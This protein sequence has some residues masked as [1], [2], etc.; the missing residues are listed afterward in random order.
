MLKPMKAPSQSVNLAIL[1]YPLLASYKLDGVRGLLVDAQVL[2]NSLKLIPNKHVQKLFGRYELD[3]LDGELIVGPPTAPDVYRRTMSGVMSEDGEPDVV[4][5]VFDALNVHPHTRKVDLNEPFHRRM[6]RAKTVVTSN[7]KL[8]LMWLPQVLIKTEEELLKMEAEALQLG[9]EGLMLRSLDG[10][11]KPGPNRATAK[12]GY[13]FKLKRFCDSEANII[14]VEEA[15]HNTNEAKRDEMGRNKRSSHKEGMVG[16]GMIGT[17]IGKDVKTGQEVRIGPGKMT[18]EER[19]YWW[20]HRKE[21]ISKVAKYKFFP[22]GGKELP[23]F[24][25][26]LG[27]RDPKDM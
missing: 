21:I 6:L 24:P 8:P 13:L 7:R 10:P 20:V 25:T 2:S 27:F 17:L 23:R 16:A 18:H 12:E 3:G 15:M 26:F 19:K 14:G 4:F 22:S 5:H 9:Y 11:Y 1:K